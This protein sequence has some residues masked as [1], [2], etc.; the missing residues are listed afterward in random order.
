MGPINV[1][2]FFSLYN[3]F[4]FNCWIVS[5]VGI[6]VCIIGTRNTIIYT[7]IITW[8]KRIMF[9]CPVDGDFGGSDLTAQGRN[10][11]WNRIGG[12]SVSWFIVP[13]IYSHLASLYV[14]QF[15][16]DLWTFVCVYRLE[17]WRRCNYQITS[18]VLGRYINWCFYSHSRHVASTLFINE[19]VN[20]VARQLIT[21]VNRGSNPIPSAAAWQVIWCTSLG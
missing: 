11:H 21:I 3:I 2:L 7:G 4:S 18:T 12:Q 15:V 10:F 6:L 1:S 20:P 17:T 9:V 14:R 16:F 5:K 19:G 13:E 8:T